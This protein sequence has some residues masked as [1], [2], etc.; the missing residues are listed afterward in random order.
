MWEEQL[1]I[2]KYAKLNLK[3]SHVENSS[4]SPKARQPAQDWML[5]LVIL[6]V[7]QLKHRAVSTDIYMI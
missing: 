7:L 4:S 1:E 3:Y 6:Q 5:D 2:C